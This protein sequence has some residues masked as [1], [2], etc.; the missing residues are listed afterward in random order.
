MVLSKLLG[1]SDDQVVRRHGL[2]HGDAWHDPELAAA[3]P[4]VLDGDVASGLALLSVDD[5]QLR[6]LR[7]HL[8]SKEGTALLGTLE[9]GMD[10]PD[11]EPDLLMWAGVTRIR[12]AWAI[13]S[14]R[15]AKDVGHDRFERFRETLAPAFEPLAYAARMSLT[16]TALDQLQWYGLGSGMAREELDHLWERIVALDPRHHASLESRLQVLSRKWSGSEEQMFAF[17][18]EVV[19]EAPAGDR[20][21]VLVPQAHYEKALY[22]IREQEAETVGETR[23]LLTIH[24][25]ETAV[26]AEIVA[27]ADRWLE[28][29]PDY[30]LVARDAHA[31]GSALALCFEDERAAAVLERAGT[32]VPH[33]QGNLWGHM[34]R[35]PAAEYART[36][37]RLGV[38][39]PAV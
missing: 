20:S 27:A 18:R 26:T 19:R 14:G 5:P 16:P 11:P 36:R 12:A 9:A 15:W 38:P 31:F 32:V 33:G 34:A 7:L 24:Y 39:L 25:T 2:T 30:P 10:Q 22:W 4:V 17:A 23:D 29:D 28:G 21:L 37:R 3:L 8:L 13:R 6:A 1:R 35:N